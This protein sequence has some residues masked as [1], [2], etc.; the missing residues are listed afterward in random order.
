MANEKY[1]YNQHT[2]R[3]EKVSFSWKQRILRVLGVVGTIGA[4][5]L[6]VYALSPNKNTDAQSRELAQMKQKYT[7]MNHQIDMM[8]SALS[9]LHERDNAIYRQVLEMNPTDN[10]VWNGGRGG[11]DKYADIRNL[12]DAELL[13]ATNEKMAKLR[14]QLAVSAKSQDK[15]LK[16]A[17][18]KERMLAAIP[19]IRPIRL[20]KK[21]LTA[22][23]GFGYRVHPVFK[24]RKMHTGIDFGARKG[25]PIYATGAGT[26]VRVE[27]KK[28]GYG[29]N[30]VI[31]HG[32]GYQTLY[33]HMSKV[34]CKVGQI[35]KR[36]EVI[37]LVGSTGTSTSPHVHY[38]VIHK[39]NK[40]NPLQFCLDGLSP[41]EYKEFVAAASAENQAMSIVNEK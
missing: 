31:D 5:T 19:S 22:L 28:S 14:H 37:G 13:I 36:G 30:V 39:G 7:E 41:S 4:Y 17:Q 6:L 2:L 35:V 3:Y 40:I 1:I 21:K 18:E 8:S 34:E 25:T 23:S 32:Y 12:S 15:V 27:Y 20:L 11:S 24:T 10:G 33:G 29:R 16:A 26:I 38:E 9:N